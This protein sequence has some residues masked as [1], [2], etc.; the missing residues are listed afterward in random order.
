[1]T[2]KSRMSIQTKSS[3]RFLS[4]IFF[5]RP[6]VCQATL[7]TSHVSVIEPSPIKSHSA[8]KIS[9]LRHLKNRYHFEKS[10]QIYTIGSFHSLL[11]WSSLIIW[12][13]NTLLFFLWGPFPR[14]VKDTL[15]RSLIPRF[16]YTCSWADSHT[17]S[18]SNV[19]ANRPRT[20]AAV[21]SFTTLN[22]ASTGLPP[23]ELINFYLQSFFQN[24]VPTNILDYSMQYIYLVKYELWVQQAEPYHRHP[25]HLLSVINLRA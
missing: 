12:K 14:S 1:M 17:L 24:G 6:F 18:V 10:F 20:S 22:P 23:S 9:T 15:G 5:S 4:H 8:Y 21:H 16:S 13:T 2:G 3:Q 19:W 11:P 25:I 7:L